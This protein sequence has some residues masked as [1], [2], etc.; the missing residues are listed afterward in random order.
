MGGGMGGGRGMRGMQDGQMPENFTG[1][2]P[3]DFSGSA[4]QMNGLEK[5]QN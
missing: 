3:E 1:E 4:P 5:N 2:A